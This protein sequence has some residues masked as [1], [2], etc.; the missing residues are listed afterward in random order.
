MDE[1]YTSYYDRSYVLYYSGQSGVKISYC[2][3]YS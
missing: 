2:V 1:R 3:R